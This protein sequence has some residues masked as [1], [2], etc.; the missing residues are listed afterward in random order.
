MSAISWITHSGAYSE[1]N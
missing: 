1:C